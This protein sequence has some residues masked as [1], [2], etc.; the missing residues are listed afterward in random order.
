[1]ADM[2][3]FRTAAYQCSNFL[4]TPR[5]IRRLVEPVYAATYCERESADGRYGGS[6]LVELPYRYQ[7]DDDRAAAMEEAI[8]I[9]VVPTEAVATTSVQP[10][11]AAVLVRTRASTEF[12]TVRRTVEALGLS[13][14]SPLL[15]EAD[16]RDA[17]RNLCALYAENSL[18]RR[19]VPTSAERRVVH[20]AVFAY[21]LTRVLGFLI[22][23]MSGSGLDVATDAVG[24]KAIEK[25]GPKMLSG[26]RAL[27]NIPALRERMEMSV[28]VRCSTV[29]LTI[30][31]SKLE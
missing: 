2:G 23:P 17:W 28:N 18:T 20:C 25:L 21:V 27:V 3:F 22:L 19:A 31:K 5:A 14:E 7:S 6:E 8:R 29:P 11:L 13:L 4:P 1:M 16:F 26:F 12:E 30:S 10:G 24:I 9:E 15:A